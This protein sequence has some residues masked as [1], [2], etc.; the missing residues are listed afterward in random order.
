MANIRI[1]SLPADASPNAGDVVPIDGTTTRKATLTNIVNA[2]RPFASQAEAEAG[3]SP[4]VGMSPLTTA[5]AIAAQGGTAFAASNRGVPAGGTL[6]QVLGKTSGSDYAM[7]WRNAGAGD[8]LS[9][10]NLADVASP[11]ASLANLNGQ[12]LDADLTAIAA[13]TTTVYGRS[14]LTLADSTALSGQLSA[15]YQPLDADLTA[16]A[17]VNPSSYSTTAQ[18]AATYSTTAQIAALYQPINIFATKALAAAYS[19]TVAPNFLQIAGYTAAG[20]G[21]A[22]LYMKVASQPSHNGKFSITLQNATVVWYEIASDPINQYMFGAKGDGTTDDT[23]AMLNLIAVSVATGKAGKAIGGIHK[24][25]QTL[26]IKKSIDLSAC[27]LFSN[28]TVVSPVVRIGETTVAA[29][30]YSQTIRL[31]KV[32][33]SAKYNIDAASVI[34]F[35]ASVAGW[36][37]FDTAIGV[38]AGTAYNSLIWL[39]DIYGFGVGFTGGG[40]TNAGFTD[41]QIWAK[42]FLNNKI[43]FRLKPPVDSGFCNENVIYGG[44]YAHDSGEGTLI[45]NCYDIWIGA[46]DTATSGA[47]NNNVFIKPNVESNAPALTLHI[48]GAYNRFIAP[49][50]DGNPK[51]IEFYSSPTHTGETAFN[52]LEGGFNTELISIFQYNNTPKNGILSPTFQNIESGNAGGGLALGNRGGDTASFP[53]IT[54]Y[55]ATDT[56]IEKGKTPTGNFRYKLYADGV[57]GKQAADSSLRAILDWK[58]GIFSLGNGAGTYVNLTYASGNLSI[59]K[60]FIP[61]VDNTVAIGTTSFRF[62]QICA[63]TGT[64]NTSDAR[65]KDWRGRLSE[66]EMRVAKRLPKLIGI[67]QWKDALALKGDGARLHAGVL[68]QEVKAAFEAEGLDAQAYGVLCHDEWDATEEV[69][70]DEGEVTTPARSAGDRYGIRYDELWAFVAAGFEAR[71]AA[72]EA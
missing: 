45:T 34:G 8:M 48:H 64:I 16:W 63:A 61:A 3:T 67:Y 40:Y 7:S 49:R 9:V 56:T 27:V 1:N 68:A 13:L 53:H 15:F 46:A 28:A 19:P 5:Q 60:N 57:Y 44:R 22:A 4:I 17:A 29:T 32:V 41:N 71:I 10:N 39:E 25:T 30:T 66:A 24:T 37:G 31:P 52:T 58:N 50:F 20:D 69:V 51:N 70:G 12:P 11:A 36:T 72:L 2:G 47:P 42:V 23:T 55:P 43:N 65:E 54:G 26:V 38:E 18:I 14:L 62:T 21:G 35:S 33:N 6:N 59:D